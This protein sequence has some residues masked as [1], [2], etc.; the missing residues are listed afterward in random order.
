VQRKE[1][2][3]ESVDVDGFSRGSSREESK[4]KRK[5][6]ASLCCNNIAGGGDGIVER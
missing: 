4:K 6:Q 5:K 1:L 2:N 3:P